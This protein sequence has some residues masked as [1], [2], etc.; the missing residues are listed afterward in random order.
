MNTAPPNS[1]IHCIFRFRWYVHK[2][3]PHN[4]PWNK[5]LKNY[6]DWNSML[7]EKNWKYLGKPQITRNSK[8]HF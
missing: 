2:D 5:N 1:R 6:Q 7:S 8:T 3:R 4:V